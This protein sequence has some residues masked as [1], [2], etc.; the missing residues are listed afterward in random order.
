MLTRRNILLGTLGLALL[1]L[2]SGVYV[3]EPDQVGMVRRFGRLVETSAPPGMHFDLPWPLT[4]V[5]RVRPDETRQVTV[6]FAAQEEKLRVVL[7]EERESEFFT[8]DQN[9]I[10]VQATLQ[11]R[12]AEP[13]RWLLAQQSPEKLLRLALESSLTDAVASVG[14][15]S[16]LTSGRSEVQR[17]V[18]D[19][20][21]QLA[22]RYSLGAVLLA[23]DFSSVRPPVLVQR[24]F[25]DAVT[26][27]NDRERYVNDARSQRQE[28]LALAAGDERKLLDQAAADRD[29]SIKKAQGDAAYFNSIVSELERTTD[30]EVRRRAR[31]LAMVRLWYESL[32][33]ILPRVKEK[34]FVDPGEKVDVV[35]PSER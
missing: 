17:R 16:L 13:T 33:R 25:E 27:K 6:G 20:A 24:E 31:S 1:W 18:I 3:V 11:F 29:R 7:S 35:I 28:K 5:D 21:Q 32:S 34:L 10:H 8:G 12:L 15:D 30:P 23:V 2:A 22:D 4:Q 26:A 14:V 19:R 9:L